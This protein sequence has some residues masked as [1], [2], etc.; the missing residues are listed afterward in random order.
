MRDAEPKSIRLSDYSA[1]AYTT[2][3]VRLHVDIRDGE[4]RVVSGTFDR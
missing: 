2:E 1:P 3:A 4:T